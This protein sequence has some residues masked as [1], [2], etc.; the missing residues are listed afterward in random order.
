MEKR[1][2]EEKAGAET[3]KRERERGGRKK[4]K[5]RDAGKDGAR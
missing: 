2:R 5:E 1:R 4:E 3:G